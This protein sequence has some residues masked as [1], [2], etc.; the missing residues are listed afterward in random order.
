MGNRK[1]KVILVFHEHKQIA[2]WCSIPFQ[3]STGMHLISFTLTMLF[4][5]QLWGKENALALYQYSC[6]LHCDA[7]LERT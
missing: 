6:Q 5:K 3:S 1:K 4:K 7:V 2:T